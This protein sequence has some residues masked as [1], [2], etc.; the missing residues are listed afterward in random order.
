MNRLELK[1]VVFLNQKYYIFDSLSNI[2]ISKN[3]YLAYDYNLKQSA[4]FSEKFIEK[5]ADSMSENRTQ[6][7]HF[8]I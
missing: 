2:V 5:W 8:S 1:K 7:E 6:C 3:A 4:R